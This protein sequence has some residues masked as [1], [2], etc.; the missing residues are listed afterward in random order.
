MRPSSMLGVAAW[1]API[2]MNRHRHL[3]NCAPLEATAPRAP[4]RRYLAAPAH[5]RAAQ[6]CAKSL[7]ASRACAA[8]SVPRGRTSRPHAPRAPKERAQASQTKQNARRASCRRLALRAAPRVRRAFR[9]T[10]WCPTQGLRPRLQSNAP[11]ARQAP[12]ASTRSMRV[13][14]RPGPS[15]ASLSPAFTSSHTTGGSTRR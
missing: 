13:P 11:S 14:A 10:I 9:C 12:H 5:S 1:R 7:S 2:R 15:L 4:L 6:D 3:V 8:T